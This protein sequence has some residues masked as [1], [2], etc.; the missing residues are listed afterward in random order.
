MS[1]LKD[2]AT[3]TGSSKEALEKFQKKISIIPK[4]FKHKEAIFNVLNNERSSNVW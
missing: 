4:A 1:E 3:N 2:V